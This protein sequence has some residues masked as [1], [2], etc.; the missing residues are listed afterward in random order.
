MESFSISA[1]SFAENPEPRCPCVLLLDVSGSMAEIVGDGGRDTGETVQQD[2]M[3]YRVVT[4][5]VSRIDLLNEGLRSYHGDL[6]GDSLASKRVE[7]AIVTFGQDVQV[8]QDFATA[9]EF[10]P[11]T[12]KANGMTP[13]GGAVNVA[14]DLLEARKN[15]YK[16]HGIAYYRPW[17][18]LVTDGA[19]TDTGVWEGAAARS[20]EG[21]KNKAF[22]FFGVGVEGANFDVLRRFSTREP[23][24][25]KGLR[26]RDLFQW[27][28]SSQKAV[29]RSTP[30][31]AV[32]LENPATPEGWAAV[33]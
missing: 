15:S 13:L 22:A 27:L 16:E 17:V 21:E 9:S 19:P 14:L 28:S 26:F 7:V 20:R 25:L 2:G 30:G 5:G 8:V 33:V 24:S 18:F 1:E 29:S 6:T 10:Q 4:G 23:L 12:L 31:D 11:P 3:T 32:P